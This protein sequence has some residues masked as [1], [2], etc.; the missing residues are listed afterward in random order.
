M[1]INIKLALFI[2]IISSFSFVCFAEDFWMCLGWEDEV[3]PIAK[4]ISTS[5]NEIYFGSY[6]G[7]NVTNDCGNSWEIIEFPYQSPR[8]QYY[9]S[10]DSTIYASCVCYV[11]NSHKD[12]ANWNLLFGN[13]TDG[14]IKFLKKYKD[15]FLLANW[16]NITKFN[17]DWSDSS[18]VLQGSFYT[19][20][21]KDSIGTLYVGS[22]NFVEA[23]KSGL[24]KSFDD[25][26]TW[27]GPDLMDHFVQSITVDSEGRIFVG[28]AGHYFN[29]DLEARLHR[30]VDDGN[31][32]E[33]L[34]WGP[35]ILSLAV[36]SNDELFIG[37]SEMYGVYFSDSHGDSAISLG[38]NFRNVN[39]MTISPDGYI[40]LATDDGV[41]RSVNST[42]G[43]ENNYENIASNFMLCQ[44]YPN[45]FNNE[46]IIDFTINQTSQVNILVYNSKGEII[47]NLVNKRMDKGKHSV[48]FNGNE[49]TS[50]LY[51]YRLKI[52][53]IVQESKKM[54]YLK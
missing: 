33:A 51:Y 54:L 46:T 23:N 12:S 50:G 25:G 19:T 31:T 30:S 9:D 32:W 43:I 3:E 22:T 16:K 8:V 21:A 36:N 18:N 42:T 10:S 4:I 5:K 34:L 7:I 26:E 15:Y 47:A 28:T 29:G 13:N 6:Y 27:I 35:Q 38:G 14:N 53:D 1:I 20:I 41:Y 17:S 44:N 24:Y 49:L 11:Y 45:P 52:N 48:N 40:Y 39:D 2:V 37:A